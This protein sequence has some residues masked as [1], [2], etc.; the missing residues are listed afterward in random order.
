MSHQPISPIKSPHRGAFKMLPYRV[1]GVNRCLYYDDVG[2][3]PGGYVSV[4]VPARSCLRTSAVLAAF[5]GSLTA[6]PQSPASRAT[7][8]QRALVDKY[9]VTCHNQKLKAADLLL[10]KMDLDHLGDGAET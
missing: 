8:P 2:R 6:A 3:W 5:V 4:K 1:F 9:C 7:A 10:D